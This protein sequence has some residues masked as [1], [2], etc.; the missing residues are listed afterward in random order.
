MWSTPV[1]PTHIVRWVPPPAVGTALLGLAFWYVLCSF[2]LFPT[3]TVLVVL[4]VVAWRTPT[5]WV[6]SVMVTVC[7]VFAAL[8]WDSTRT[9]NVGCLRTLHSTNSYSRRELSTQSPFTCTLQSNGEPFASP[10][11]SR[12]QLKPQTAQQSLW[13]RLCAQPSAP[14]TS[15]PFLPQPHQTPLSRHLL[16]CGG[17][18][19]GCS[20]LWQSSNKALQN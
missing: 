1:G 16:R 18:S 10:A 13:P 15:S 9:C 20:S 8:H 2:V 5:T 14:E 3:L 7:C 11:V 6:S 12:H 19:W 17:T 4:L